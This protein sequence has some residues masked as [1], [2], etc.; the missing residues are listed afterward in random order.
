MDRNWRFNALPKTTPAAYFL[1]SSQGGPEKKLYSTHASFG[2][3]LSIAWSPDGK[4]IAFAD[5]PFSG[6]HLALSLLS[7]DTLEAKQIEHNDRC[8]DETSPTFS[9][10]GKY[11][12]YL[13]YP[14]SS[15]FSIAMVTSDRIGKAES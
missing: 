3:S 13:C 12:A 15:D 11:L 7:V 6:G 9:H 14:T 1:V 10:D 8:R 2:G 5:A 4:F